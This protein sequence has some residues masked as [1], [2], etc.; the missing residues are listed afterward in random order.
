[1]KMRRR[2]FIM[3]KKYLYPIYDCNT[4][5]SVTP[6]APRACTAKAAKANT[7]SLHSDGLYDDRTPRLRFN[8]AVAIKIKAALRITGRA[9][10]GAIL[11]TTRVI[12]TVLF[13]AH[14]FKSLTARKC[15]AEGCEKQEC[16][17]YGLHQKN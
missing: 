2:V 8:G 11:L 9:P 1:M 4:W 5:H 16:P 3:I 10:L 17:H 12:S 13:G 6:H 15:Q 14:F 7:P